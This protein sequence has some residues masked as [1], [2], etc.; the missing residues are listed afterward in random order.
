MKWRIQGRGRSFALAALSLA[1]MAG[2]GGGAAPPPAAG[3]APDLGFDPVLLRTPPV[4]S[5]LGYRERLELTSAQVER[6]DSIGQA[7]ARGEAADAADAAEQAESPTAGPQQAAR[8]GRQPLLPW[9]STV[10]QRNERAISALRETLD[11]AQQ[12]RVCELG[13]PEQPGARRAAPPAGQRGPLPLDTSRYV[14]PWCDG[15]DAA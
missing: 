1:L 4:Y 10:A 8:G 9:L 13:G 15:D 7:L 14:W 3:P 6:I 11:E 2:C 12:Q 5:L